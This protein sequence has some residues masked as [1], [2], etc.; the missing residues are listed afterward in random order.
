MADGRADEAR[1]EPPRSLP[2]V[3]MADDMVDDDGEEEGELTR[4]ERWRDWSWE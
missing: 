1:R 3:D 4:I 2:V